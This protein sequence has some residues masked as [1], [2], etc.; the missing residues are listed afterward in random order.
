MC[1]LLQIVFPF[2]WEMDDCEVCLHIFVFCSDATLGRASVFNYCVAM[3]DFIDHLVEVE[4]LPEDEKEE[5]KVQIPVIFVLGIM[6]D[7]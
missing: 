7:T 4:Q 3:Q 1:C 6:K 2:D 5:F